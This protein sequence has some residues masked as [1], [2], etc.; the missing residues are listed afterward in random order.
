MKIGLYQVVLSDAVIPYLDPGFAP[1][2][3]R[4]NPCP[5]MRE[6]LIHDHMVKTG[7]T[8][9]H[10]LT[11]VLSAKFFVKTNLRSHDI[12]NWIQSNPGHDIYLISGH[13][14]V[15]Y[16]GFNS[17]ELANSFHRSDFG[18][19]YNQVCGRLGVRPTSIDERQTNENF[20]YCSYFFATPEFWEEWHK[21]VIAP[22][23][24]KGLIGDDL[25]DSIHSPASYTNDAPPVYL[26]PFIYERLISPY[27][28]QAKLKS[29]YYKWASDDIL[30]LA[31]SYELREHL[32]RVMP[33]IDD[34]DMRNAWN[35]E[36]KNF[37]LS[38]YMAL[39]KR[40][41]RHLFH[42]VDANNFNIPSI[43]I[44]Q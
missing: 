37:P 17:I 18:D 32:E 24:T 44:P 19:V 3:W 21:N 7:I 34:M 35:H 2:D 11:G 43:T 31:M 29:L 5:E 16:F 23:L 15:T 1:L 33:I 12:L 40:H 30:N 4:H 38:E 9:K 25:Y 14:F 13:P 20:S 26:S 10:R 8:K 27:I 41:S 28:A 22:I 39:R 42:N 6:I 36:N